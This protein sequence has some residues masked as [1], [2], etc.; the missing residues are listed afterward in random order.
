MSK[1]LGQFDVAIVGQGYVGFPLAMAAVKSGYRVLGI[2][3]SLKVT[4]GILA[5]SSPVIDID[6]VDLK[7]ALSQNRYQISNEFEGVREARIVV[8][9]VPTPLTPTREPDLSHVIEACVQISSYI[10]PGTLVINEST[11][12]P[13]TLRNQIVPTIYKHSL[14]NEGEILF[15]VAPERVNP[16]DKKWTQSNTP[17]LVAG[18]DEESTNRSIEFYERFCDS[19]VVTESPEVAET[20]KLL[21]NTFRL[22]NLA[23]INEIDQICSVNEIDTNLVIA[24]ASTKP[25][26]YMPFY[27]GLGVGGHCIPVDPHYLTWWARKVNVTPTLIQ[28]ASEINLDK[29]KLVARRVADKIHSMGLGKKVLI[30]GVTYKKGVPD[31]RESPSLILKSELDEMGVSTFWYDDLVEQWESTKRAP[32]EEK[33][34]LI[35][36]SVPQ[37]DE[38]VSK[39]LELKTQILDCT[40]SFPKS[41][42]VANALSLK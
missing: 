9:C 34:D 10:Q 27:P 14:L 18:L 24:A 28:S 4:Q 30:V 8:L 20:A 22:V 39:L 25:Y 21:E 11:S 19:V 42:M 3:Y 41:T 40:G 33:Y 1:N 6:D 37:S 15:A 16:G 38:T 5:G 26:G 17:R 23:L 32:L 13:G 31:T 7:L 29:P 12:Y 36:Y 2:D 35:I